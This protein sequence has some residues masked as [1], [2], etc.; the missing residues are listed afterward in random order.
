MVKNSKIHEKVVGVVG[1]S[2]SGATS[3]LERAV[4]ATIIVTQM[5]DK[6]QSYVH[7]P[8]YG[9]GAHTCSAT[10]NAPGGLLPCVHK[11]EGLQY[12]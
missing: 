7:C 6:I 4:G 3:S 9:S 11:F 12:S 8:K 5:R 2:C 10:Q 1:I